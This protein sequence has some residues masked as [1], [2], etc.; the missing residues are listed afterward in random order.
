MYV[1]RLALDHF[2][3]WEHVVVDLAAG[4]NIL[5]GANGLGKTNLVEAV[6]VLS[7]G[8][9]H[10]TSGSLPLIERGHPSATIRANVTAS[11]PDGTGENTDTADAT[12]FET[13]AEPSTTTYELTVA[14]RG[15]NRA[16]INGGK[17]TYMR[18]VIGAI[19]SIAFTPEDQRLVAGD[20]AARRNFL[21]QAGAL[22]VNGYVDRL[23]T[24]T[25][26]ARQ[27]TALLKQLGD[28]Q[29]GNVS[30]VP[31]PADA[32]LSGL[33]IW[34][35]QFIDVGV[36]LTRDRAHL[37]DLL[38]GPF[39][40]IYRDL[41]GE[42]EKAELVYEPSFDEIFLYPDPL[43]RISEHFQRI[44]P[45]EV[46]RGQNLIGPHRDD[47][48]LLLDGM[49]AREFASNGEMWTMALALKMAL[50]EVVAKARGVK[51]VVILDDVFAQLD[52][53][54][55]RQI[56]DFASRQDQVLITVAAASDIP[57]LDDAAPDA[58][59]IDVAALKREQDAY[60]HPDPSMF[61]TG[62]PSASVGSSASVEAT[63]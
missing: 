55:R 58:H 12:S 62:A 7:T 21:N 8:S 24:I 5:Q 18:E 43:P 1:S 39:A 28:R 17:S 19:P 25:K 40:A 51:P 16:R 42:S 32:A 29:P 59:V 27:R 38:S 20:P 2:R 23:Q 14:A 41:A 48:S 13:T 36:A 10:R 4:V 63:A 50:Y 30:D 53:S 11:S 60:L 34:T 57:D 46:A 26:I 54:R 52:E 44:Y 3:S 45:G 33:E 61:G 15:A 9:S 31:S 35:G 49:L 22:L 37:V 56:L 47:L 6:E